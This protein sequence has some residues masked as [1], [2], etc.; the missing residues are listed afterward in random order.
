MT[1]NEIAL[2]ENERIDDLH[3]NGYKLIQNPN[4]FCFGVDTVLLSDFCKI[5]IGD[6]VLDLGTGNGVLPILLSA[7]SK[8]AHFTGLEIQEESADMA[9]RSVRLNS[10]EDMIS[11][12]KGDIKNLTSIFK[13]ASFDVIVSNPPYMEPCG[14]ILSMDSPK[15]IARHE[16]L[17]N[18][19][20][21][22]SGASKM[23]RFAGRFYIVHKPHRVADILTT[24]RTH[25]MEAKTMRFVQ[26]YDEKDPNMML[27]EAT[28]GGKSMCKVLPP[29]IIYKENGTYTDEVNKIYYD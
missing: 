8:N 3:R 17:C 19:N 10:L 29:L 23:L 7:K 11:I 28:R 20:D 5:K 9:T 22:I 13:H 12:Q 14:G 27:I 6:K 4:F 2:K 1:T 25:S 26:S 24:L 16:V 18:L 15:A 21:I